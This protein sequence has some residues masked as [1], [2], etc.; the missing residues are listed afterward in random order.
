MGTAPKPHPLYLTH[1]K[2]LQRGGT[3]EL[4]LVTMAT[5]YIYEAL[6]CKINATGFLKSKAGH[7]GRP[8]TRDRCVKVPAAVFCFERS[9]LRRQLK[10]AGA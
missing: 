4:I 7:I 5:V 3:R 1:I 2:T 10:A 6:N 8:A 9:P